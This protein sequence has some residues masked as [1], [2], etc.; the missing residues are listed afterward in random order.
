[1]PP[2]SPTPLPLDIN[3]ANESPSI[4]TPRCLDPTLLA[5]E[6][7]E[8]EAVEVVEEAKDEK[9]EE[10]EEEKVEDD[11]GEEVEDEEVAEGGPTTN[12]KADLN[13]DV[14][15]SCNKGYQGGWLSS[16][17][18]DESDHE[19]GWSTDGE[20]GTSSP[21][22]TRSISAE[23]SEPQQPIAANPRNCKDGELTYD[24][25]PFLTHQIIT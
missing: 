4:P 17:S 2:Q 13:S 18:D 8:E 16:S 9:A 12:V 20:D 21:S 19:G 6:Q 3:N 10:M 1:M 11:E 5:A 24:L 14:T 22:L 25:N 7:Q 15:A 23:H